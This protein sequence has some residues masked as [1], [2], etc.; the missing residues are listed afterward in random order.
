MDFRIKDSKS[1]TIEKIIM[2]V[3]ETEY[4]NQLEV[5]KKY[6]Y[7]CFISTLKDDIEFL[8]KSTGD[9]HIFKLLEDKKDTDKTNLEMLR[10]KFKANGHENSIL[11]IENNNKNINKN[12][13]DDEDDF[14]DKSESLISLK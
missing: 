13:K 2:G 5:F 7:D 1:Q 3:K 11:L 4:N 12:I 10:K 9:E 14:D 8:V 6:E